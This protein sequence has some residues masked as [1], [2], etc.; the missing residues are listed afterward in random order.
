M[1][2]A[3]KLFITLLLS[4]SLTTVAPDFITLQLHMPA[5]TQV[6]A[7]TKNVLMTKTGKKYHIKKCGNGTYYKVTLKK[8][9][10]LGL[11]PCKKCFK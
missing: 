1:K 6:Q 10:S 4:L 5:V 2:R 8:A 9:E 3:K 7:K 11:T